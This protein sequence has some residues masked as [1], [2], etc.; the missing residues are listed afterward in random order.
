MYIVWVKGIEKIALVWCVGTLK[1]IWKH[2]DEQLALLDRWLE[3]EERQAVCLRAAWF[4]RLKVH[5]KIMQCTG[6]KHKIIKLPLHPFITHLEAIKGFHN[7]ML[8]S[9]MGQTTKQ[10]TRSR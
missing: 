8:C 3:R 9:R 2:S 5:G 6:E 4:S 10:C 1:F 7:T